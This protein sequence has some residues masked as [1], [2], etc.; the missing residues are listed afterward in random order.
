MCER[1]SAGSGRSPEHPQ[2]RG[3][4]LAEEGSESTGGKG[5]VLVTNAGTQGKGG[6]SAAKAVG[7][8]RQRRCLSHEH[9][10]VSLCHHLSILSRPF[11]SIVFTG[12]PSRSRCSSSTA[13]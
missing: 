12:L 13:R 3:S 4:V 5:G 11:S 8:T 6:V 7:N 1:V 9:N 10:T 2:G